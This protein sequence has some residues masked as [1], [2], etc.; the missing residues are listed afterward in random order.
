MHYGACLTIYDRDR[1]VVEYL[2]RTSFNIVNT[3]SV[4]SFVNRQSK[5]IIDLTLATKEVSKTHLE[6]ARH[7][8]HHLG[9]NQRKPI[10]P[11]MRIGQ[12]LRQESN[13][14]RIIGTVEIEKPMKFRTDTIPDYYHQTCLQSHP[15]VCR[16]HKE[17]WWGLS[18]RDPGAGWGGN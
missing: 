2:F 15:P 18:L 6:Q 12:A 14:T 9:G 4:P 1:I 8:R 10:A 13:P 17:S 7:T 5:I 11:N 3:D 16:T